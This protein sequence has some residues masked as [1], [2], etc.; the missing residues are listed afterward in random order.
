MTIDDSS[1]V[2]EFPDGS[3]LVKSLR[4]ISGRYI[5]IDSG[6]IDSVPIVLI[7][8][9][10][11]PRGETQELSGTLV[12]DKGIIP[13]LIEQLQEMMEPGTEVVTKFAPKKGTPSASEEQ[14]G[15]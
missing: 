6:G 11:V 7:E 10:G 3:L 12:M 15:L 8:F 14:S 13:G 5:S 1:P 2:Q 9:T 4:C